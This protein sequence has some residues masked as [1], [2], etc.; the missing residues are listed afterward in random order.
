MISPSPYESRAPIET[1]KPDSAAFSEP[2]VVIVTAMAAMCRLGDT[3]R[4]QPYS[5][6]G[7]MM[8]EDPVSEVERRREQAAIDHPVAF[9]YTTRSSQQLAG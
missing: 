2:S 9:I 6:L 1:P 3:V 4:D 8:R 5:I 7:V